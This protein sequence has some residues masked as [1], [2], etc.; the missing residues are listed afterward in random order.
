M[1]A[2]GG[3]RNLRLGCVVVEALQEHLRRI[4]EISPRGLLVLVAV[5]RLLSSATSPPIASVIPPSSRIPHLSPVRHLPRIPGI[6]SLAPSLPLASLAAVAFPLLSMILSMPDTPFSA[7]PHVPAL[8]SILRAKVRPLIQ[9]RGWPLAP[10]SFSL[11]L[12][13]WSSPN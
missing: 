11:P 9:A 13:T 12:F 8:W 3:K 1:V 2:S 4:R 6:P 10:F 5:T 7:I